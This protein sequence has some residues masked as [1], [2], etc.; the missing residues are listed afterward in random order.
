MRLSVYIDTHDGGGLKADG[1]D[2]V[3]GLGESVAGV[4]SGDVD[5]ADN[6]LT[7][8]SQGSS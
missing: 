4:W 5:M 6:A 1:A 3:N 8:Q 2:S 7:H